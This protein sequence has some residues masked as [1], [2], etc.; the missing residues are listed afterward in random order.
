MFC[1]SHRTITKVSKKYQ[2]MDDSNL[3]ESAS[4]EPSNLII[5]V[6]GGADKSKE[7]F[8]GFIAWGP[9][10]LIRDA[11]DYFVSRQ[12]PCSKALYFGYL[13][14]KRIVKNIT[15][16]RNK[17]PNIRIHLVGHSRGAAIAKEIAMKHLRKRK[18]AVHL[19]ITLDPVRSKFT[20]N[21]KIP[22]VKGLQNV[23]SFI[24]VYAKPRFKN[25]ADIVALIGG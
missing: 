25:H 6:G 10:F 8:G 3:H 24:N 14:R 7:V 23:T 5:F 18:M 2:I 4:V 22:K 16:Y 20:K 1:K 13:E 19:L 21:Y 17:H 15:K 9:T 12:G 11:R